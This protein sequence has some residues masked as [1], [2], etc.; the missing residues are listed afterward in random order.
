MTLH[1]ND[2]EQWPMPRHALPHVRVSFD[3]H[4]RYLF[5]LQLAHGS[6]LAHGNIVGTE[7]E[8]VRGCEHRSLRTKPGQRG[9]STGNIEKM[10]DAGPFQRA[11][12]RLWRIQTGIQVNVSHTDRPTPAQCAATVPSSTVQSPPKVTAA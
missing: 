4:E 10:R 6:R 7:V 8:Y 9:V 3:F 2:R 1:T 11:D 12:A 5:E